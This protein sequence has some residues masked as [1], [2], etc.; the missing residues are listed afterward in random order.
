MPRGDVTLAIVSDTFIGDDAN[1]KRRLRIAS[2]S[3]LTMNTGQPVANGTLF[4]V[5]SV[6]P[7]AGPIVSVGTIL[8]ADA[9]G[10]RDNV[11]V[12]VVNGRIEFDVEIPAPFRAVLPAQ[13]VV[14]STRGT[15]FGT[16]CS[17]EARHVAASTFHR[18]R[19][20]ARVE[21]QRPR[22]RAEHERPFSRARRH[23]PLR[24]RAQGRTGAANGAEG[25]RDHRQ[26]LSADDHGAGWIAAVPARR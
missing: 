25:H 15:A 24:H 11:Q 3:A 20:R 13:A 10:S 1:A 7:T 19:R 22:A 26:H 16:R 2:T 12:P 9:D 6:A 21:H 5:R 17:S 14:Y 8:T 4:T 18:S 23:R